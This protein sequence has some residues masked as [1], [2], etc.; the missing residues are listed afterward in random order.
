[1][2][3]SQ[4]NYYNYHNSNEG[5]EYFDAE[6]ELKHLEAALRDSIEDFLSRF[7]KQIDQKEVEYILEIIG[8]FYEA[9]DERKKMILE[10]QKQFENNLGKK[11]D[12]VF[13]PS[14][15]EMTLDERNKF[16]ITFDIS[17]KNSQEVENLQ[18][19]KSI[20][21][22]KEVRIIHFNE[23]EDLKDII[24]KGKKFKGRE[25]IVKSLGIS[26]EELE[27]GGRTEHS[28]VS[29]PPDKSIT[30]I[31][32]IIFPSKE[33]NLALIRTLVTKDEKTIVIEHIEES[34]SQ[35]NNQ[36]NGY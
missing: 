22:N 7:P 25:E 31:E 23:L 33:E 34:G 21:L 9:Y 6:K 24:T 18:N 27:K 15:E 1:M 12:E 20:I 19:L 5:L 3:E 28:F 30:K 11:I 14:S 32:R 16:N 26:E 10:K 2:I 36:N 17:I 8:Y 29:T 35:T 4:G 13:L